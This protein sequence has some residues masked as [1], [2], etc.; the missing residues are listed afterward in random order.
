MVA[1]SQEQAAFSYQR[2]SGSVWLW[3]A[4]MVA[5][6]VVLLAVAAP[7]LLPNEHAVQRHGADAAL[8]CSYVNLYG[9]PEHR[10]QCPDGNVVN[11]VP[12]QDGRWALVITIEG[13]TRTAFVTR[14]LR[15]VQKAIE[16]CWNPYRYTHP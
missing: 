3:V 5:L 13:R 16:G 2:P 1:I 11:A 14:R 10:W 15:T 9:G 12:M 6:V 7:P 8:A 4:V